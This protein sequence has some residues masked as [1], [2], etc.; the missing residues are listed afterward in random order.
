[1]PSKARTLKMPDGTEFSFFGET[2]YGVCST[3]A[4]TQTK[5]VTVDGFTSAQLVEGVRVVVRFTNSQ[6]YNGTPNLNVNST[7]AKTIVAGSDYYNAGRYEWY[8]NAIIG[9]IYYNNKWYIEDGNHANTTYWGKTKLTNTID[10]TQT[11]ALTPYAV[12]NAGYITVSD[13]SNFGVSGVKGNEESSYRAGQ[14]NLTPANIGAVATTGD[15][16]VAGNKN[17]TGNSHFEHIGLGDVD[18]NLGEA[19]YIEEWTD[20]VP[21]LG[22]SSTGKFPVQTATTSWIAPTV[23]SNQATIRQG[24][25]YQEGKRTYVQMEI[26]LASELTGDTTLSEFL[27][28]FPIPV[29]TLAI[30]SIATSG[31]AYGFASIK[32]NGKMN[33]RL[34]KTTSTSH[35]IY[36][37][38]VYT[39]A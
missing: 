14:V 15:E 17:F 7:G 21:M 20:L 38:G 8:S 2:Y 22:T 37:T 28:N 30:L 34:N 35:N 31:G 29:N 11:M 5:A 36:I 18:V 23:V 6:S 39:T 19:P 4:S 9:F 13:L 12:Y 26:R 33:I 1:M 3:S 10:S 16:T 32:T 25:Y 27:Q 24:G